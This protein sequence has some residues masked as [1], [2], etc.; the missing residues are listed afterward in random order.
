[1]EATQSTKFAANPSWR[2]QTMEIG[3]ERSP[4]IVID[5]F[6]LD[7]QQLVEHAAAAPYIALGNMYPGVRAP[8]PAAYTQELLREVAPIIE[9]TLGAP[10]ED[11]LELCAFSLV[12]TAPSQLK[13]LQRLPHF[14]GPES[15]RFAFIHYLCA[16]SFGGTSFYRHVA[17]GFERITV[18]RLRISRSTS[19]GAAKSAAGARI[20]AWAQRKLRTHPFRGGSIQPTDHLQRQ[21]AA[22][23]G[24]R[25]GCAAH[26]RRP[27]GQTHDQRLRS[28]HSMSR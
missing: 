7:A 5:D 3:R 4:L 27:G 17:T 12:T 16:P 10:P 8:A 15:R 23:R 1:M 21:R 22:F 6:M 13:P 9:R 24:Y 18:E 26:G 28:P 11:A 2:T 19:P 14:D 25:R 20:S